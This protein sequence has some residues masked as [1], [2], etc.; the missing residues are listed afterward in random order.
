[1]KI[2]VPFLLALSLFATAANSRSA[3]EAIDLR[4]AWRPLE[5][6]VPEVAVGRLQRL[7]RT[8]LTPQEQRNVILKLAEALVAAGDGETALKV[9]DNPQVRGLAEANFWRAQAFAILG[10]WAEALA[11]YDQVTRAKKGSSLGADALLGRAEALRAL[12]QKDEALRTLT[13]LFDDQRWDLRARFRATELLLDKHDPLSAGSVLSKA[14]P[15]SA[16]EKQ[17]RRFLRGRMEME[18]S[19]PDKALALFETILKKSERAHHSLVLAALFAISDV[20]LQLKTPEAG[21]DVL[22]EFIEHHPSDPA[23][24]KVFAKLDRVYQT[25]RKASRNELTRWSHDPAQPRRALAQWYLARAE[26]R[27]GRRA[28]ALENFRV[29][30]RSTAKWPALVDGYIEFAQLEVGDHHFD[31]ALRILEAAR[32]LRPGSHELA[33]INWF[34][35]ETQYQAK[36]F[37]AAARQFEQVARSSSPFRD[38][39]LFNASL[40][41]LQLGND[42]RFLADYEEFSKQTRDNESQAELLLEQGLVQAAQ[43]NQAAATSL[44]TFLRDFPNNKRASEAWV[45]LS[46]LAFHQSAPRLDEARAHLAHALQSQPNAAAKERADYLNIWIEDAAGQTDD[47]K[48]VPL[49]NQFVHDHPASP[50]IPEV[51]MKLAEMYY[52]HQD[53]PNAQTQFELLVG[54]DPNGPLAEKAMFFA[55]ESAMASMGPTSLDRALTLF[56]DVVRKNGELKWAARNEQAVIERKLGK[57]QDA[58]ALY[59]EILKGNA[60]PGEK[61]EALCGKGDIYFEM[62]TSASENYKRAIENYDQLIS[63]AEAPLHWRNQALFKK[64]VCLEKSGDAAGSLAIFYRV[65]ENEAQPGRPRELFWFYKA[66][67][68]AAR[69]LEDEAKWNSASAI[70][71]KLAAADG[72]RSDEAKARLAQL[73]LEHF[74]WE[75]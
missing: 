73:R 16:V 27:A 7:L 69:L 36:R 57:P 21:D 12:N 1:M 14:Q 51:R 63:D 68:N 40:G 59:D 67:F 9:L 20:H 46:E 55:A 41:W 34:T 70:Y 50:F 6:G 15:Q 10:R 32:A 52:R 42:A 54:Q 24:A 29:L 13:A 75:Q 45:A 49:A 11:A 43:G 47:A 2:T 60:K 18:L 30:T 5:E 62:G 22:E 39:A 26:L 37:E 66:G 72:M 74:L 35:A 64:G 38:A 3:E 25:E 48:V 23:L 56:G 44:R 8:N 58:L 61:R 28:N 4:S 71:Q 65:L 31:E 19:H 53:F 33:K 17:Q